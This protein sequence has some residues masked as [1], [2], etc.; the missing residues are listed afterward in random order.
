[1]E[2]KKYELTDETIEIDGHTLHRIRALKEFDFGNI[3]EGKL[4]GFIE[5]EENL[6]HKG[7]CWVYDNAKVYEDAQVTGNATVFE[8]ARIYGNAKLYDNALVGGYAKV[9]GNA[10]VCEYEVV[11]TKEISKGIINGKEKKSI[12][13]D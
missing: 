12:E 13:L 5:K 10:E 9:Y 7:N 2:E 3:N 4:G 1:M 11:F 8:D 6:S